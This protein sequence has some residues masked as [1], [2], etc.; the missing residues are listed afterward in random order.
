MLSLKGNNRKLL[1]LLLVVNCFAVAACSNRSLSE[2]SNSLSQ[3]SNQQD[4]RSEYPKL[5]PIFQNGK[6]GFIDNT[7][8]III[9]PQFDPGYIRWGNAA[10]FSEGLAQIAIEQEDGGSPGARE[11]VGFINTT[12]EVVIQPQFDSA[13]DFSEGLAVVEI[14][15]RSGFIDRTGRVAIQPQWDSARSFSEGLATVGKDGKFGFID[16]TGK[17]VIPLQ[18]DYAFGFSEGLAGVLVD[19]KFAFIDQ[20]GRIVLRPQ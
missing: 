3:P 8:K 13:Y 4:H 10:H 12:G 14:N 15:H 7:G 5:F 20:T 18:F 16:R 11:R 1:A 17:V 6:A 2:P 19:G 9:K